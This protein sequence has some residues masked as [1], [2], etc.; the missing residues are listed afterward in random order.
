MTNRKASVLIFALAA[1][2]VATPVWAAEWLLLSREGEC[3]TLDVLGRKL[4]SLPSIQ[5]PEQFEAYLKTAG[6]EYSRK[7]HSGS[8]GSFNEFLV[9]SA[10]LS[11]VL[12]PRAQC[13]NVSRGPS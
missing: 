11:V 8:G 3:A 4:P 6:L 12:V 7:E 2:A 1:L 5:T 13:Q 9:P 10:G